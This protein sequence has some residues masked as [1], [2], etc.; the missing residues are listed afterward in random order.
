MIKLSTTVRTERSAVSISLKDK[1]MMLGSCFS[2]EIGAKMRECGFDVCVNPFGPLYNPASLLA[3]VRR[4]DSGDEFTASDCV[5]MGAG[6]GLVCSFSHNTAFARET[7]EEFLENAN[8]ALREAAQFWKECRKVIITLGTSQ[9]WEHREAGIVGNCLKR[10]PSEFIHRMLSPDECLDCLKEMTEKH[11][12]KEF[13]FTVSPIRH[14][15]EG[16]RTNTLS[17]ATLHLALGRLEQSSEE[18]RFPEKK[19]SYFPAW[20]ILCDEL[21]DY[22]FYA[23]D[24]V[25]PSG[26]A[27]E[28]IWERFLESVA[29]PDELTSIEQNAR[30]SRRNAHRPLRG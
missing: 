17:K 23:E 12:D 11:P 20:E 18:Q 10:D 29:L 3:A 21:R 9:V 25:H 6:S 19:I 5:R 28:I 1:V 4:L 13:I 15:G 7:E 24:L 8:T 27:V 22:R 26:T 16:A 30:M 14:L 2:D